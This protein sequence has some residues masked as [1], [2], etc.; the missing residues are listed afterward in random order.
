MKMM[1]WSRYHNLP[2]SLLRAKRQY[3]AVKIHKIRHR[4][5]GLMGTRALSRLLRIVSRPT[6]SGP[7]ISKS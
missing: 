5:H 4:R 3:R 1:S 6:A 7:G 2:W